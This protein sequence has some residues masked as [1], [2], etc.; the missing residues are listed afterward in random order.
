MNCCTQNDHTI[1]TTDQQPAPASQA[2]INSASETDQTLHV[3][4]TMAGAISAGAYTGGVMDYLLE[5]L[6][7]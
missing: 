3:G 7:S 5:A 1:M 4:I 2:S 6:E